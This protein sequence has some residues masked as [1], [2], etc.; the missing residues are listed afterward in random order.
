MS[1]PQLLRNAQ[2]DVLKML[3]CDDEN[4][5][6]VGAWKVAMSFLIRCVTVLES[7]QS[8][9]W[10]IFVKIDAR[11]VTHMDAT[12][13]WA[14]FEILRGTGAYRV[15]IKAKDF[16]GKSIF[17][18]KGTTVVPSLSRLFKAM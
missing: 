1:I 16:E 10:R 14:F 3:P 6:I 5:P 18:S 4:F 13:Q 17:V 12:V 9:S 7:P 15:L 11:Q 8:S 2:T